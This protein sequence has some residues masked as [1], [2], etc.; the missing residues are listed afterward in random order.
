MRFQHID[1]QYITNIS[2]FVILFIKRIDS[3]TIIIMQL[4]AIDYS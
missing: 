2:I 3:Q 1:Y 4:A